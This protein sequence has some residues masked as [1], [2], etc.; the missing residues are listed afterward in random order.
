MEKVLKELCYMFD[1]TWKR[2]TMRSHCKTVSLLLSLWIAIGILHI[3][4]LEIIRSPHPQWWKLLS[5][6]W[7]QTPSAHEWSFWCLL[8][9]SWLFVHIRENCQMDFS[10]VWCWRVLLKFIRFKARL[11]SRNNN[12]QLHEDICISEH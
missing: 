7:L 3:L 4:G 8:A 1:E 10:D 5:D 9:A 6:V 11:K 2:S 12:R